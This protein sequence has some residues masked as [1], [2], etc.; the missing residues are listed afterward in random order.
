MSE[1]DRT[2]SR[3]IDFCVGLLVASM[4]LYAAVAIIESI[5]I[6]LCGIALLVGVGFLIW[7]A[8]ASKY[9]GW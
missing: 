8:F 1:P 4:A 6:W 5:W 2:G 9:R 7:R 3:F